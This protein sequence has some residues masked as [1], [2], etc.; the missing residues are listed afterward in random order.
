MAFNSTINFLIVSP[1]STLPLVQFH[2][3]SISETRN[4]TY[5][6]VTYTFNERNIIAIMNY[7]HN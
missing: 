1:P 4:F 6:N 7:K 3:N 2:N 5:K